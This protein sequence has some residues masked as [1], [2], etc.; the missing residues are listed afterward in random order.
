MR[1]RQ[2]VSA[3]FVAAF[4][5]ALVTGCSGSDATGTVTGEATYAG[6][7]IESGTIQFTPKDGKGTVT[8]GPISAGKFS[9]PNVPVGV[10]VVSVVASEPSSGP[11]SSEESARQAKEQ[12]AAKKPPAAVVAIPAGAAGNDVAFEVKAG[13]NAHNVTVTAPRAR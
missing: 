9:V 2:L 5:P 3:A 11:I 7:P 12:R 13:A 8:G 1:L 10:M 6:T 4:A